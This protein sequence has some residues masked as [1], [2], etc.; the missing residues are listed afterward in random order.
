[1]KIIYSEWWAFLF[2]MPVIIS[3]SLI[4]HSHHINVQNM[5]FLFIMIHLYLVLKGLIENNNNDLAP[6]VIQKFN[7]KN[8][9]NIILNP[10]KDEIIHEEQGAILLK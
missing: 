9:V 8:N 1:M 10:K 7:K 2:T 5:M 4:K 6:K 3:I